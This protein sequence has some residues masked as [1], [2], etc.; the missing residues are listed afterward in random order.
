MD[1]SSIC[2]TL[3]VNKRPPAPGSF[4]QNTLYIFILS[5]IHHSPRRFSI[6]ST[7]SIGGAR[8]G[9]LPN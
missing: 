7:D 6:W 5:K 8:L 2:T 4:A 9:E 3:F 1:Q